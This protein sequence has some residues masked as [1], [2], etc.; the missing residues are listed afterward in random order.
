MDVARIAL[1]ISVLLVVVST[2]GC[3]GILGGGAN[4]NPAGT[5]PLP[6]TA[7][8]TTQE[9]PLPAQVTHAASETTPVP[10][11]T[12]Y[13]G[14]APGDSPVTYPAGIGPGPI[15]PLPSNIEPAIRV[16][17]DRVY[18]DLIA[19]YTG[20]LGQPLLRKVLVK[21]SLTDGQVIE[22]EIPFSRPEM[23]SRGD[24]VTISGTRGPDRV[25]VTFFAGDIPYRVY[26][27][28]LANTGYYT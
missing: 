10:A 17:K 16:E 20:G 3:T 24:S 26:N 23:I 11:A 4:P 8:P 13:Q 2:S 21:A 22:K 27:D 19:T 28:T 7:L 25:E 6:T 12:A 5:T 9:T 1:V 15:D 14:V 18:S